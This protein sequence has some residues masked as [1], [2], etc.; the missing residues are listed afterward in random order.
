MGDAH[1]FV[2]RFIIKNFADKDENITFLNKNTQVISPSI[3]YHTQMQK[4]NFYSKRSL[5]ELADNFEHIILNPIFESYY[6]VELET[7]LAN[8]I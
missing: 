8:C 2:P 3:P 7:A 4:G 1:H 6:N 5:Q